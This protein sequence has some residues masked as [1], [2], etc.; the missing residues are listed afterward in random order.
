M[1]DTLTFATLLARQTG[2]MLL[3]MAQRPDLGW[4]RKPDHSMVTEADLAADHAIAAAIRQQYPDDALLS[5]ELAPRLPAA[6]QS[7]DGRGVWIVDPVDGTTNYSLGLPHWGVILC[8]VCAGQ[9][10]LGVLYFPALDELYT[11]Q[12]GRG[13]F[14]NEQPLDLHADDSAQPDGFFVCCSRTFR[15]YRVQIPYKARILGSAAYSLCSVARGQ[16]ALAFE[17]TPK[18]W[19]LAAGWLL[20]QEA[21]GQVETWDGSQPFPLAAT[22]DYARQSFPLLMGATAAHI[23]QL[24]ANIHPYKSDS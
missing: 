4:Q 24:R 15:R 6:W 21:G 23:A 20:L 12:R 16:A 19:D 7:Q 1:A 10:D 14:L 11:A 9:P 18:I 5:E 22:T 3:E 2:Q 8:R 17:S 13:A